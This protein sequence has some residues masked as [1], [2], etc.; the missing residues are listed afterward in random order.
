MTKMDALNQKT[1]LRMF[2]AIRNVDNGLH[3]EEELNKFLHNIQSDYF[4]EMIEILGG[5]VN[6]N[7]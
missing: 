1:V 5:E 2:R 4:D 7:K 6:D 3:T